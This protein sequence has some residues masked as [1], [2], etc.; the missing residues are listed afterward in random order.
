MNSVTLEVTFCS[1]N[2]ASLSSEVSGL[3]LIPG[4]NE[5]GKKPAGPV[6]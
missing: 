6:S 2:L 5:Q 3:K 4:G 1:L